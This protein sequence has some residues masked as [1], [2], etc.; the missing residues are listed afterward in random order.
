MSPLRTIGFG[1]SAVMLLANAGFGNP[2]SEPLSRYSKQAALLVGELGHSSYRVREQATEQLKSLG[3]AAIPALRDVR[4]DPDLEIRYRARRLLEVLVILEQER[5]LSQFEANVETAPGDALPGWK[6][7]T[8]IVGSS[9][10]ARKLFVK[11]HHAEPKLFRLLSS[12]GPAFS[13]EFKQRCKL[14]HAGRSRRALKKEWLG[15]MCAM[16]FIGSDHRLEESASE[17]T[18][19][20]S[21][22]HISHFRRYSRDRNAGSLLRKLLGTWIAKSNSECSPQKIQLAVKFDCPEGLVPALELCRRDT[23][24]K[25]LRYAV[26]TVARFGTEEDVPV[27]EK[28][29]ENANLF[30]VSRSKRDGTYACQVRDVALVAALHLT[31]QDPKEYGFRR[32]TRNPQYVFVPDSTGFYHA[33]ERQA[34]LQKWAEW[35]ASHPQLTELPRGDDVAPGEAATDVDSSE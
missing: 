27:L 28:L 1:L 33:R 32:L 25:Q 18:T 35:K 17:Q 9:A 4:D 5:A 12:G 20:A 21:R 30:R 24:T 6:R 7:Y 23:E 29:F 34:A 19:I 31:G 14:L 16:L 3:A 13:S 2:V 22:M 8:D 10:T 15:R 11:M 26:L